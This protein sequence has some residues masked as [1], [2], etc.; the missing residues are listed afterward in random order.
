[1]LEGKDFV[2]TW[3]PGYPLSSHCVERVARG[4]VGGVGQ[5]TARAGD[6]CYGNGQSGQ[7][8]TGFKFDLLGALIPN[9]SKAPQIHQKM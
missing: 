1:M 3:L 8:W 5:S 6:G 7:S 2:A 9:I 4:G